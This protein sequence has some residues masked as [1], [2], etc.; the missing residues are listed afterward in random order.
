MDKN[1]AQSVVVHAVAAV[2]GE[3]PNLHLSDLDKT[4]GPDLNFDSLDVSQYVSEIEGQ[5]GHEIPDNA[6]TAHFSGQATVQSGIDWIAA[7]A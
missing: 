7:N 6:L 3:H 5:L 4:I 2:T 1:Q